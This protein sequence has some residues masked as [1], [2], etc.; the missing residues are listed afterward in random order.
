MANNII[1]SQ[2]ISIGKDINIGVPVG[3]VDLTPS[4]S[5][6]TIRPGYIRV[7]TAGTVKY[8]DVSGNIN[9]RAFEAKEISII[10]VM[11]VFATGTGV[12]LGIILYYY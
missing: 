8:M 6:F 12:G 1:S 2:I 4:D 9:S 3:E 11:K 10:P 7:T 5:E